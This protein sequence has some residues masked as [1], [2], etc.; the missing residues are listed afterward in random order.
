MLQYRKKEKK[1]KI[2]HTEYVFPSDFLSQKN[3]DQELNLSIVLS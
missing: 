1:R 3:S 2:Q